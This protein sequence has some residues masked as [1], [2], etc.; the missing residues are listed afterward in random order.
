MEYSGRWWRRY[1]NN[2]IVLNLSATDGAVVN[3]YAQWKDTTFPGISLTGSVYSGA[4]IPMG[5]GSFVVNYSDMQS[6]G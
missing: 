6:L 3:L 2:Q 5:S 4:L 1:A